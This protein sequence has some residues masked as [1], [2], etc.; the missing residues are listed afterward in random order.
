MDDYDIITSSNL[1]RM[2]PGANLENLAKLFIN[3]V[4]YKFDDDN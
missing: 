2:A 3:R 1:A 4:K